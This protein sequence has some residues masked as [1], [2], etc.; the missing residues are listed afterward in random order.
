MATKSR[1]E[2]P[3]QV[4]ENENPDEPII[5]SFGV[6]IVDVPDPILIDILS[7]L[8]TKSI[9]FCKSVCRSWRNLISDPQFAKNLF[10][11]AKPQILL[12]VLDSTRIWRT[13]FLVE[14]DEEDGL[15]FDL[16]EYC[17]CHRKVGQSYGDNC[18]IDLNTILKIPLRNADQVVIND[19]RGDFKIRSKR[20]PTCI[21]LRPKDHKY[22]IV[23]S[24]HGLLC[25]S[26]PLRNDPLAVSNPVT[27]EFV[28][29][30]PTFNDPHDRDI[31]NCGLGF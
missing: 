5:E 13:L 3:T 29:L 22:N 2:S 24:C 9:V 27:C 15:G 25:L 7:R 31:I 16:K 4:S 23:N 14:P 30:P 28:N 18:H 21:K 11:Q 10:A 12:H 17:R 19:D 26:E 6:S 1:N 8:P 20:K